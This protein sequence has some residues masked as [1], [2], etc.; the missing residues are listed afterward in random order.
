MIN[1]KDLYGIKHY[2]YGE[3]YYGSSGTMRFRVASDPLKI[4]D[5]DEPKLVAE[6]WYTPLCYE[7]TPKEDMTLKEFSFDEEGFKE[8]VTWLNEM[9]E[10]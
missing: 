1:E 3:A 9:L 7:K 2:R 10:A 5:E 4:E 8:A 6:V